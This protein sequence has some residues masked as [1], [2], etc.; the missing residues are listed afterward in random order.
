MPNKTCQKCKIEKNEK[1]FYYKK[2]EKRYNSWCKKCLYEFQ[3]KRW[4]K[5]KKEAVELLG[6]KCCKCGYNKKMS[7]LHF[8]HLDSEEKEFSW[9]KMRLKSW[10]KVLKE[11]KKCILVCANCHAETHSKE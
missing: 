9:D 2:N 6:G 3:K 10:D 4:I 1:E 7:A 5:R 8:H 11:L